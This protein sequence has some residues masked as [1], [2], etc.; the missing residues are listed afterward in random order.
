MDGF[1]APPSNE[2]Q[3]RLLLPRLYAMLE[4]DVGSGDVTTNALVSS[5][6]QAHARVTAR[7]PGVIAGTALGAIL[8]RD[9][10]LSVTKCLADGTRVTT[11]ATVLE[12]TGPAG[13]LL[14]VERTLLNLLMH[15]SGIATLTAAMVAA[16]HRVNPRVR[17]A[18]TRKTA[19]LLRVFDKLAVIAGGGDPHRWRLDDAVL[20]KD[21]HLAMAG[22]VTEAVNAARRRVSFTKLIEVEVHSSKQALAAVQAGADA[23]LLDNMTPADVTATV[24]AVH[25]LAIAH[26]PSLEVSGNITLETI[27]DYAATGV[28]IVSAGCLT[29]SAPAL[30][31]ALDL[32]PTKTTR[33]AGRQERK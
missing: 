12:A 3:L 23:V 27:A 8:L 21:N 28:D 5:T 25:D 1:N 6:Q 7:Q 15:M 29:H 2:I 13:T 22:S 30:D 18:A 32:T 14:T 19:P 33:P 16:A 31:M 4:E 11:N 9:L 20:I 26:Q 17:V 24:K 10:G